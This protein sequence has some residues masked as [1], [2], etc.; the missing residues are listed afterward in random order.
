[1]IQRSLL[2]HNAVEPTSLS[3][4]R[5]CRLAKGDGLF[6]PCEHYALCVLSQV[7]HR[8][9]ESP[10]ALSLSPTRLTVF[11]A[12]LHSRGNVTM[13]A[14]S[15][16]ETFLEESLAHVYSI[17]PMNCGQCICIEFRSVLLRFLTVRVWNWTFRYD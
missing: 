8:M 12:Q 15:A 9:T 1:M 14:S 13:T 17:S 7:G 5:T 6:K 11:Q 2:R 10:C 4:M 3:E 16:L